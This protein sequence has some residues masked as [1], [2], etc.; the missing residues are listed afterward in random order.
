MGHI[1]CWYKLKIIENYYNNKKIKNYELSIIKNSYN[2]F[3]SVNIMNIK[4]KFS[5]YKDILDSSN[6]GLYFTEFVNI[7]EDI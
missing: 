5:F 1:D 3:L 7:Y 4:I 6:F 2:L